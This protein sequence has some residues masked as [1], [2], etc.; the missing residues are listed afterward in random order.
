MPLLNEPGAGADPQVGP[1]KVRALAVED[2]NAV[3]N[4][5]LVWTMVYECQPSSHS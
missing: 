2:P 5:L 1:I 4:R 3:N